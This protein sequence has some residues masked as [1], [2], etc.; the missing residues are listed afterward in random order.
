MKL[1]RVTEV[2]M[3][4]RETEEIVYIMARAPFVEVPEAFVNQFAKNALSDDAVTFLYEMDEC[5]VSQH[6]GWDNWDV[7]DTNWSG[8][9]NENGETIWEDA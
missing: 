9:E 5:E 6:P 8:W 2:M 7:N 3:M 4:N 1:R